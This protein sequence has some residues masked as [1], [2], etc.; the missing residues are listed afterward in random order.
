MR[1]AQY[2]ADP[3]PVQE[4]CGCYTCRTFSRA[5]LRHLYK[6]NEITALRLGTIH[7]V[8]FMLALMRQIRAAIAANTFADFRLAF[9]ER[10]QISNQKVRHEQRTRYQ[11][12]QRS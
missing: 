1:S 11:A 10:Y 4:D 8:H 5:Y 6:A 7:N 3:A 9:L 2:A 12:Q